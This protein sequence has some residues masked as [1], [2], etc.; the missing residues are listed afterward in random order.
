MATHTTVGQLLVNDVLPEDLRDHSRSLDAKSVAKLLEQVARLHPEKYAQVLQRLHAVGQRS[1]TASGGMSFGLEHL[2]KTKTAKALE[3]QLRAQARALYSDS[4][5]K[6]D[7][8]D[9]KLVEMLLQHH[10]PLEESVMRES[11]EEGNPLARQVLSGAKGKAMN[12]KS[13]RGMDLLYVDHRDRPIPIPILR[14][15]SQGLT[16][17]EY[18]AGSFGT[19]KGLIDLKMATPDA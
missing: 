7:E 10:K 5:L 11:E 12:L 16:P 8:K 13:L 15:Y 19:R 3:L 6:D 1:A 2:S 4:S 9:Q 17:V 14:S 18:F